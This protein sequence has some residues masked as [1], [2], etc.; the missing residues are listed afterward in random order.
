MSNESQDTTLPEVEP[1]STVSTPETESLNQAMA[2]EFKEAQDKI[3]RLHAEI[4]NVRRR[5]ERDVS[6]AHK[7][8]SEKL[9]KDILPVVE[10]LEQ[11]IAIAVDSGDASAKA[12]HEGMVLTHKLLLDALKKHGITQI[13]PENMP[14]HTGEMEAI[15]M[16]PNDNVEPNTVLTVVQKGYKLNDRL[17][18]AALVIVSTKGT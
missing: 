10:S 7:Y 5:A 14:F 11:G 9:L 13:N 2:K 6:A 4:D 17:L 16:V 12:I 3:L 15:S 8:G 1:T 18:K